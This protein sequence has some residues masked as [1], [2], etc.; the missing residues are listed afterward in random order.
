MQSTT[1]LTLLRIFLIVMG[2]FSV[3]WGIND[4][5]GDG[6]QS[7]VGTK[8]IVGGIA[9]AAIS[10]FIMTWAIKEVGAAEAQA[11]IGAVLMSPLFS[12]FL[13]L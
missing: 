8:K 4:M 3:I 5:F 10:G 12:P 13:N 11:G 2:A 1:I 9:F 7:S 6:Q